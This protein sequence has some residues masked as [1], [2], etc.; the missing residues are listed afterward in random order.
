MWTSEALEETAYSKIVATIFAIGAS[1][2]ISEI[3]L[4]ST[5]FV[6]RQQRYLGNYKG[7]ADCKN[8]FRDI[9]AVY[10]FCLLKF[11]CFLN[12]LSY[13]S[14]NF[15]PVLIFN[16]FAYFCWGS[17]ERFYSK[18]CFLADKCNRIQVNRICHC[19]RKSFRVLVVHKGN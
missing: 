9:F 17:S 7:S 15:L 2:I 5:V 12:C 6:C 1:F 19:N 11:L 8:N 13:F 16:S 3:S 18:P 14:N 10:C 4:L